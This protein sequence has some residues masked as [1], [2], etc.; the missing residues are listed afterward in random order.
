VDGVSI[1]VA[2]PR[3]LAEMKKRSG[4]PQDLLDAEAILAENPE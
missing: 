3:D 1:P 4:H 2:A